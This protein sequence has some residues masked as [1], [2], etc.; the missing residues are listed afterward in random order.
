MKLSTL[1]FA[2][3][4][5]SIAW[6]PLQ[7]S[8]QS[9][10]AVVD[11][12]KLFEGYYKTKQAD[13]KIKERAAELD[14]EGEE[15]LSKYQQLKTEYEKLEESSK[16]FGVSME[17]RDRRKKDAEA[18][19]RS[20]KEMEQRLQTFDAQ[21]RSTLAEQSRRMRERV[22]EE[23]NLVIEAF[24][25]QDGYFLVLNKD[26]DDRN[27]TKIVLFHNGENDITEKVLIKLNATAAPGTLENG[28]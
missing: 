8:A 22:L 4:V 10:V 7:A 12:R 9:K 24:A 16:D 14:K 3:L 18:R 17:E 6:V 27:E 26:A 15:M 5:S 19:L 13:A 2:F 1:I 23:I 25:K 28:Q 21:A 20:I 11:L